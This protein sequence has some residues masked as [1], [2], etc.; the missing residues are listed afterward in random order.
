[1]QNFRSYSRIERSQNTT[2]GARVSATSLTPG[3]GGGGSVPAYLEA[4]YLSPVIDDMRGSTTPPGS[5]T[6]GDRYIVPCG[7]TGAWATQD[8]K[9]AEW[10]GSTWSFTVPSL[11]GET[12]WVRNRAD[13]V[14][15]VIVDNGT[16]GY[17]SGFVQSAHPPS[18]GVWLPHSILDEA[19][20]GMLEVVNETL[21][22][23][24]AFPIPVYDK[25]RVAPTGLSAW[26]GF[27][28]HI[29]IAVCSH[30]ASGQFWIFIEPRTGMV[31]FSN[32]TNTYL[33]Y[34]GGVFITNAMTEEE[35]RDLVAAFL[36]AGT[37]ISVVHDDPGDTLTVNYIGVGGGPSQ[38]QIEDWAAAMFTGGSHTGIAAAYD[39]PGG[40]V[41]LTV[42]DEF[43]EDT[44]AAALVAGTDIAITYDDPAG[45]ITIDYTGLGGS[46][47]NT[48]IVTG[49]FSGHSFRLGEHNGT[50][51]APVAVLTIPLTSSPATA[52]FIN[53]R[54]VGIYNPSGTTR[55]GD[56]RNIFITVYYDPATGLWFNPSGTY[57]TYY[58][59]SPGALN[60]NGVVVGSNLQ[61]QCTFG[62]GAACRIVV[63]AEITE[64]HV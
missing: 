5:P 45:T 38:E 63:T 17:D 41:N 34:V 29:A 19:K 50:A 42:S 54:V 56:A 18:I 37:D 33:T 4:I 60:A 35:V 32:F 23:E 3:S 31:I 30:Q 59:G 16:L 1:M 8:G 36:T 55:T 52:Y 10:N 6:T 25:Y 53:A 40:V 49:V 2:P 28:N 21:S 43:I 20:S 24:P 26:A 12:V 58:A 61:I 47:T 27:D 11:G 51:G 39:D 48:P 9:I 14:T 22:T 57:S 64:V 46:G 44:V 7:A 13:L 62:G 15:W